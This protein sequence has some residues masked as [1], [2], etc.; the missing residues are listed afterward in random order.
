[1]DRHALVWSRD[2]PNFHF[3]G[4]APLGSH[5]EYN[6]STANNNDSVLL[7]SPVYTFCYHPTQSL[8][9]TVWWHDL[10]YKVIAV[11]FRNQMSRILISLASAC[12]KRCIV[13]LPLRVELIR[14]LP[15]SHI[16]EAHM[17]HALNRGSALQRLRCNGFEW[18]IRNGVTCSH[19]W[20]A[21]MSHAL[22]GGSALQRHRCN[23]FEWKIRNGVTFHFYTGLY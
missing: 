3:I 10:Q 14:T 22:N 4:P 15:F 9:V 6:L 11:P 5:S 19:I 18:K 21:R 12:S 17:S 2:F 23:G 7:H 8:L 1:M 16:W 20:E 13:E